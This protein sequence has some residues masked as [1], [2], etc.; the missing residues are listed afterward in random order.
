MVRS[1]PGSSPCKLA[2]PTILATATEYVSRPDSPIL[3]NVQAARI[4][5]AECI[6]NA[7]RLMDFLFRPELPIRRKAMDSA[8]SSAS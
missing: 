5:N 4:S 8:F 3:P 1:F 6:M 2:C 7:N